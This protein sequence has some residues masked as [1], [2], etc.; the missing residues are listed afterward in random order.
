MKYIAIACLFSFLSWSVPAN[1]EFSIL[2]NDELQMDKS[3]HQI[4]NAA[5]YANLLSNVL[6]ASTYLLEESGGFADIDPAKFSIHGDS[7]QH[8]DWHLNKFNITDPFFSGTA[9]FNVPF[10]SLNSLSIRNQGDSKRSGHGG[11]VLRIDS[12]PRNQVEI[13]G[14]IPQVGDIVPF[15]INIMNAISGLHIR[16]RGFTPPEER[17]HQPLNFRAQVQQSF[18][19]FDIPAQSSF[20]YRQGV[21]RFLDFSPVDSSFQSTYD[22]NFVSGT[23]GLAL[24]PKNKDQSAFLF[25]EHQSR[26]NLFAELHHSKAE[27]VSHGANTIFA[28]YETTNWS[29]SATLKQFSFENENHE[30]VR[31]IFDPDGEALSPFIPDGDYLG[32]NLDFTY[33]NDGFYL[34]INE[35]MVSGQPKHNTWSNPLTFKGEN[36][37]QIDWKSENNFQSLGRDSI[38]LLDQIKLGPLNFNYDIYLAHHHVLNK[39]LTNTFTNFDAGLETSLEWPVSDDWRWFTSA[40]KTPLPLT[41]ELARTLDPDFMNGTHSLADG[42]IINT[43]GGANISL[44]ENIGP[45]N[46]YQA[47]LGFS[48]RISSRWLLNAQGLGRIFHQL[49]ELRFQDELGTNGEFVNERFYLN[50]GAKNY[51]LVNAQEGIAAYWGGQLQLY[52]FV[53]DKYVFNLAFTA[54]SAVGYPVFGNGPTANDLAVVDY[55]SANPNTNINRLATFDGDRAF[56]FRLVMGRKLIENLWGH[57]VISHRDGRPFSFFEEETYDGQ[58]SLVNRSNRG[59]PLK[60]SRPLAGPRE[61]FRLNIDAS[62]RYSF[63]LNELKFEADL[64]GRNLFDFGNEISER[65]TIPHNSERAGLEAE[66][67]RSVM[68]SLRWKN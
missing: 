1:A 43:T 48:H 59:S 9:G 16:E 5:S 13:R 8:N 21:R 11:M 31:E 39:S 28:G 22:E 57:F 40:S 10:R 50:E 20:D 36:Y 2:I 61:D 58:A 25:V 34:N 23:A 35:R 67:P 55:S 30:F 44:N 24:F 63:S 46:M 51:E 52:G 4:P 47:A 17:R 6:S 41:S 53:P 19:L 37:G 27:T 42:R 54:Y 32:A 56:L 65:F 49:Y 62:V 66:I 29:A 38:G 33:K 60:F 14:D 64:V 26:D 3:L 12:A 45:A 18:T 68:L 7:W 15:A